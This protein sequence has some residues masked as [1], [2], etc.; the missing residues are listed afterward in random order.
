[1]GAEFDAYWSLDS[2]NGVEK[3]SIPSMPVLGLLK[4][5]CI[6]LNNGKFN[7]QQIVHK[8]DR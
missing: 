2:K 8:L 6:Y 5:G 7:N 3:A 1:M 4:F